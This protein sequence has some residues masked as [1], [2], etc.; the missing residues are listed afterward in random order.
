M[1]S[2]VLAILISVVLAL[3]ATVAMV[4]YVN[5][6]DRRAI[7]GQ[8]PVLVFVADKPIE[9][10]TSGLNAANLKLV[11]EKMVPR[12]AAVPGAV[13]SLQQIQSSYAAVD[14]V[15]GE[16][17]LLNRWVGAEEVGGRRLLPIPKGHQAVAVELDLT[18]QVAGFITPGDSVSMFLSM[19]RGSYRNPQNKIDRSEFLLHNVQVLAVGTTALSNASS[20]GNG[21]R[22]NQ[23]RGS[24]TLTAV[25]LAVKDD[26][27]ERVVYAAEFGSIYLSLLPANPEDPPFRDGGRT[28]DDVVPRAG[29]RR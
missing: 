11:K 27:I 10:G 18:R 25:T 12:D 3:V 28:G 15:K 23:G 13:R 21:G 20:Q 17:L 24:Q 1:Q 8:D 9:A 26:H 29:E 2:R 5:G 22:V 16:Q 14:I 7:E 4:V 6:A 19:K